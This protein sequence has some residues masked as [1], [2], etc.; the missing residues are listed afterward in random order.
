MQAKQL[1]KA[2]FLSL[3]PELEKRGR[4]IGPQNMGFLLLKNDTGQVLGLETKAKKLCLM[5]PRNTASCRRTA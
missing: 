5:R 3:M 1:E 4:V 2:C